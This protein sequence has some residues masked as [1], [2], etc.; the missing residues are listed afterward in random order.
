MKKSD[1][2]I[3]KLAAD[4]KQDIVDQYTKDF[5]FQSVRLEDFPSI[6]Q[7]FYKKST[8][9]FLAHG[10][11]HLDDVEY[12][13][14]TKAHPNMRTAIRIFLHEGGKVY[15]AIFHL[16]M[17][18]WKSILP[19]LLG[20]KV[21]FR[22]KEL[23]SLGLNDILVQSVASAAPS[24]SQPSYVRRN[25]LAANS[26]V[27]QL[28]RVH[29]S[30]VEAEELKQ[31][32]TVFIIHNDFDDIIESEKRGHLLECEHR[33]SNTGLSER[34]LLALAPDMKKE[35]RDRLLQHFRDSALK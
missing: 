4:L 2:K 25:S 23:Q 35:D 15:A 1:Q 3:R 18:G 29:N 8:E 14:V 32:E 26:T 24:L 16:K 10:F 6:D 21:D 34:E 31:A 11:T 33:L 9:D 30:S 17:T 28:L 20:Q 5:D 19:R 7:N 22:S 12:I 27:R 13:H